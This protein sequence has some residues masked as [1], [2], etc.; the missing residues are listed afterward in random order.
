MYRSNKNNK[1][2]VIRKL[3]KPC[4]PAKLNNTPKAANAQKYHFLNMALF[5]SS[6]SLPSGFIKLTAKTGLIKK[7][8]IREAVKVRI[9]IVGR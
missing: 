9:N 7:A 3:P 6:C 1:F 5:G 8:T 4:Q 2:I